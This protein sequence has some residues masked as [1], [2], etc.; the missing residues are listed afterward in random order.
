[1][2]QEKIDKYVDSICNCFGF[3]KNEFIKPR[4]GRKISSVRNIVYYILHKEMGFSL[5]KIAKYFN[6]QIRTIVIANA[7]IKYRLQNGFSE[8]KELYDKCKKR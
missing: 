8:E 4:V 2:V 6:R 5:S 7:T 1:M 3:E